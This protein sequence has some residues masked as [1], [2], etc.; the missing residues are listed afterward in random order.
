MMN[1]ADRILV[2]PSLLSADWAHLGRDLERLKEAGADWVHLDIMDGNFV[3]N[4]SFGADLVARLR[5]V[6]DLF[7]DVHLMI[8]DPERH[9][10]SFIR[11]GADLITLHVESTTHLQ[12]ALRRIR[13]SG[14]RAG[15]AL[16]PSTPV[17]CLDYLAPDLDLVLVMTV[18]PGFGGQEFIPHMVA[19]IEEAASRV[20]H[21]CMVQVDGGLNSVNAPLVRG[22]G[23]RVLV[24]GSYVFGSED[25]A[26]AISSLRGP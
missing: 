26:G 25:L 24:A 16:N 10:E 22:A 20:G 18:N 13:E 12:G 17:S 6:S 7:F 9:L 11:A 3:P 23:A 2:A 1:S 19:K 5:Q 15:V 4:I 14:V 8:Q 21:C